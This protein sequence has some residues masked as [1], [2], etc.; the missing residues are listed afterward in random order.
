MSA[1]YLCD[2]FESSILSAEILDVREGFPT[3]TLGGDFV[4]RVPDG[5]PVSNPANVGDLVTQ[6]YAGLLA[7]FGGGFFPYITFDDLLDTSN[8]DFTAPGTAG[9]FGQRGTIQLAAE[10]LLQ[11]TTVALTGSAPTQCVVTWEAFT[12]ATT[13]SAT[14]TY[15]RTYT[16]VATDPTHTT[17]EVSFNSGGSWTSTMDGQMLNVPFLAQGTSFKIR[18]TNTTTGLLSL[19]SWAL[20]Y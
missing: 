20:I 18:I 8:V 2:T 13:D 11:S 4:L 17:C 5:V 7:F 10:A 19:G 12:V 14:G 16:E 1:Y 6:K 3:V 9:Q 15:T